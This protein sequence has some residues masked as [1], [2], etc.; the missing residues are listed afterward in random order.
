MTTSIV[1]PQ[2]DASPETNSLKVGTKNHTKT[3]TLKE[4][5]THA[6]KMHNFNIKFQNLF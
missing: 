2:P 6:V 1:S 4:A 3:S 5:V